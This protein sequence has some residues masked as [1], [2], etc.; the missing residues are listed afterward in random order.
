M[1]WTYGLAQGLAHRAG[2]RQPRTV[3][4]WLASNHHW[5]P[6]GAGA[7]QNDPAANTAKNP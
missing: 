4:N 3:V 6:D 5:H 1:P 7:L 2:G